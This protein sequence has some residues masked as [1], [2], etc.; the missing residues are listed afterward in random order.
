MNFAF[1]WVVRRFLFRFRMS[2]TQFLGSSSYGGI[3]AL[4]RIHRAMPLLGPGGSHF[5]AR[6]FPKNHNQ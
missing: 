6:G 1:Y 4:L 3:L 5:V 2:V